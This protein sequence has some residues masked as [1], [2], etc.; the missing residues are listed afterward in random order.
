MH[1]ENKVSHDSETPAHGQQVFTAS[2]FIHRMNNGV[3]EV[4]LAKRAMTKKFFPGVYEMLGGH[5]DW[6]EEMK[7]GLRREVLEEVGRNISIGDPFSVF[8]YKNDIKGSHSIEVS[9][10]AV[11]TDTEDQLN[12]HPEDH[13]TAAWL[14]EDDVRNLDSISQEERSACLKGFLL[15]RGEGHDTGTH[16]SV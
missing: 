15:L 11:F 8:D 16:A 10:Y 13:E 14:T 12:L 2:A 7:N 6:G 3:R 5:I 9:Y 4:F 1:S